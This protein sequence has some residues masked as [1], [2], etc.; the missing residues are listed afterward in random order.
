MLIT[1]LIIDIAR[2]LLNIANLPRML[3]YRP[4]YT[5]LKVQMIPEDVNLNRNLNNKSFQC[6]PGIRSNFFKVSEEMSIK[7]MQ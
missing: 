3:T 5:D 1:G 6:Q 7:V 4:R 2:T